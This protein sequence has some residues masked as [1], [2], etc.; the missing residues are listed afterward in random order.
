VGVVFVGIPFYTLAKYRGM[1]EAV[2]SLRNAGIL[3]RMKSA[4]DDIIDL[5]DVNCPVIE[6]DHGPRN[7]YNFE[8]FLEGTRRVRERLSYGLDKSKLT[9]CLGG[10]C[11]FIIGALTSLKTV[12]KGKPGMVWMDAHGDFNTPETSPS[13][14]IGGMPLALAC[15]RGP[16]LSPEIEASRP[17]LNEEQVVHIGSRSLDPGEDDA[18]LSSIKVFS[19]KDTQKKGVRDIARQT[20]QHLS[21]SS[22]WIIAHLDVDVFDPSIMPGVNF[23]EPGGLTRDDILEIFR[24]LQSTGKLKVV[25][26]TAYNPLGDRN[27]R[28]RSLL[29]DLAPK[30]VIQVIPK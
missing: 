22:E 14:F 11:A 13:G 17:L 9:F 6:K 16:K 29:L 8:E 18:L 15:G 28:G 27:N 10:E 23:P 4:D 25:D 1:A 26:L 2:G 3:K 21:D 19:A 24:A 7:L 30:L 20:A 5:G 12:H